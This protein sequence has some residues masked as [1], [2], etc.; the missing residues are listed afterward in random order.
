ML[1][2]LITT[3]EENGGHCNRLAL[4]ALTQTAAAELRIFFG[5][6]KLKSNVSL[7]VCVCALIELLAFSINFLFFLVLFRQSRRLV[8]EL[9][10][11]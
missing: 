10:F 2:L 3:R 8:I 6:T 5:E 11:R 4:T 7:S 9:L 1:L